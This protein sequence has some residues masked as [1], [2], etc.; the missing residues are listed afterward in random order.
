[1]HTQDIRRS[2]FRIPHS[3]FRIGMG[4][5][6]FPGIRASCAPVLDNPKAMN[7]MRAFAF[8]LVTVPVTALSL[9]WTALPA[10][11]A[12]LTLRVTDKPPPKELDGSIAKALQNKSVQLVAGDKPVFEFWFVSELPLTQKP[13]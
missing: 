3:A 4:T 2:A 9:W 10:A 5:F 8:A 13:A 7:S 1:M 6:L 11:G 12:E